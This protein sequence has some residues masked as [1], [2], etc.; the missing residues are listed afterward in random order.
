M[1]EQKSGFRQKSCA[2]DKRACVLGWFESN[3][4]SVPNIYEI[5]SLNLQTVLFTRV[6]LGNQE[7]KHKTLLY[8][9]A[10]AV[11]PYFCQVAD[12]QLW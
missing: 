8:D 9:F 2:S 4:H 6:L 3:K 10:Q 7:A 11:W 12:Y 5:N 1:T